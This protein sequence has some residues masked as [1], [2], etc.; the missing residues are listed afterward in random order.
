MAKTKTS[1]LA[2]VLFPGDRQDDF[3]DSVISIP[4]EQRRLHTD[5][6]D[7]T[8]ETI[9]GKL[10][11]QSIYIPDFQRRYVWTDAQ[12]SRLI[13][14]LIIQCP[15]PVI[16]LNQ[17]TDERLSVIDGNQRLKSLFR[18]LDNQFKLTGL[19][20]YPELEGN[21]FFELD[22]RFQRHI[23]NR[24][25]R[26]I[27]ILKETHPQVKFDVFERLNTGSVRLN[28]QELRHGLYYGDAIKLAE[29]LA[30]STR[31]S[32][33]LDIA[34]D[35]RMKAEELVLRFLCLFE[36]LDNYKKPLA[37]FISK[38]CSERRS[39]TDEEQTRLT[40]AFIYTLEA[41]HAIFDKHA[42]KVIGPNG[43]V[44]SKFNAALFDAEMLS[45]ARENLTPQNIKNLTASTVADRVQRKIREDEMFK[46]ALT[47]A[48]SDETQIKK[49]V[50]VLQ[51]IISANK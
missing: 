1:D 2:N 20:A 21:A 50:Q 23:Q 15:I 13:E 51:E 17:E 16:Y 27:S 37:A 49:R 3:A 48:T 25:L 28:P 31:L 24:T 14:S 41:V 47:L 6:Y 46:K 19:T 12:A 39:I 44:Q 35:K 7:F 18:Y 42:F 40:Q 30:K 38:Y 8:V 34:I 22:I 9:V 33:M 43:A 36:N 45:V 5:T 29:S 11:D 10:R 4:P 26:C 32:E